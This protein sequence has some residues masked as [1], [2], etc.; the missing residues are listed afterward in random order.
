MLVSQPSLRAAACCIKSLYRQQLMMKAYASRVEPKSFYT[1]RACVWAAYLI[2]H[3]WLYLH[4]SAHTLHTLEANLNRATE[5]EAIVP[6]KMLSRGAALRPRATAIAACF[7]TSQCLRLPTGLVAGCLKGGRS[8]DLTAD[9]HHSFLGEEVIGIGAHGVRF[10][11][12]HW[13]HPVWQLSLD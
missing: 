5:P 8:H 4:S 10:D 6:N 1:N 9:H 11:N 2:F 7:V 12:L 3:N 13:V